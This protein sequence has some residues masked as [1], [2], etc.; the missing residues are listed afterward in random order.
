MLET[1]QFW[2]VLLWMLG[3]LALGTLAVR[4]VWHDAAH[5]KAPPGHDAEH[6]PAPD[7][8]RATAGP[9]DTSRAG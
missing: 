1:L 6:A 9:D 2:G 4:A 3:M 8:P 7:P 5:T